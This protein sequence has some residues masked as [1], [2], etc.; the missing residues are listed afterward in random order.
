MLQCIQL[1]VYHLLVDCFSCSLI[2]P[3]GAQP[4]CWPSPRDRLLPWVSMPISCSW[5]R[6]KNRAETSFLQFCFSLISY[7]PLL[8]AR[9][10]AEKNTKYT[11]R[12]CTPL[13]LKEKIKSIWSTTSAAN[14][15]VGR[16]CVMKNN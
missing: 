10:S 13:M 5:H 12:G 7:R 2:V 11:H 1:A 8:R 15:C 6:R 9:D 14:H 4:L 16:C 3:T